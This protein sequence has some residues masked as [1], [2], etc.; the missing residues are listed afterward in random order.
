VKPAVGAAVESAEVIGVRAQDP[1]VLQETNNTVVWLR[2]APVVAKVATHADAQLDLRLEHAVAT[3]LARLGADIARPVHAAAPVRHAGTGFVVTFW[4]HVEGAV[5]VEVPARDLA[6]SLQGLHEALAETETGLPS[7]RDML[8]RARTALDDDDLMG[9]LATDDRGFLRST[10][11]HG[12][13]QLDGMRFDARRLHGEPHDGNRLL[14][15]DG[16]RWI[17]FEKCSLGPL[18]WDVAFQPHDVA[19]RFVGLDR[20]LLALLRR[21]NSARVAAWCWGRA[22]IPEMRRHGE[23]HLRLLRTERA[24]R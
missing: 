1:V 15:D 22:G 8:A 12:L 14:T 11:D 3:E 10:Y 18:E 21:L 6:R 5:R 13:A 7:F 16:L 9:M 17:D 20:E 4:Q 23:L 19:D 2:P 24:E